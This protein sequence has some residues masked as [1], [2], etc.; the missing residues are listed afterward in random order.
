MK[1]KSL[2]VFNQRETSVCVIK[3][4]SQ[5]FS[6]HGCEV[7]CSKI[8]LNDLEDKIEK[9]QGK[10]LHYCFTCFTKRQK[11]PIMRPKKLFYLLYY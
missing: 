11:V 10:R 8:N 1:N 4:W 7:S 2:E 5:L 3:T 9:R 6:L